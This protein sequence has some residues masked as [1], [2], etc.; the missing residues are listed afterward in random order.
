MTYTERAKKMR[1]YIEQAASALDEKQSAS[2]R[3][4]WGR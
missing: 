1:P 3:S 2:H 4:F